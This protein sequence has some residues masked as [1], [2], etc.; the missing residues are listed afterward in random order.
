MWILPKNVYTSFRSALDTEELNWDSETFSREC[1]RSLTARSKTIVWQTW[2]R[3]LK[4]DKWMRLLYA[5][6]LPSSLSNVFEEY[7]T[8]LFWEAFHVS[9]SPEHQENGGQQK[10]PA[11]SSPSSSKASESANHQLS[12]S[13]LLK[14]LSPPEQEME[15]PFSSMSCEAWNKWV[16][17]QRQEYSARQKLARLT[18]ENESSSSQSGET[19]ATPNTF[20]HMK[21]RPEE[22]LRKQ[23]RTARKGRTKPA[24]LREQVNPRAVQIYK[25]ESRTTWPTPTA[26]DWK[27][28]SAKACANVPS[29]C[30]LGR[31]VHKYP[32]QTNVNT[33]GNPDELYLNPDWVEQLMGLE[34]GLTQ[35]PSEWID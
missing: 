17:E 20:D 9:H 33:N 35:L 11:T 6:A 22:A 16:T 21:Q 10:I 24:N 15:N 26:R 29:N 7:L 1:E 31:E 14:E 34:S 12:F 2:Q 30:L 18:K 19:W 4:R 3:K 25:E 5:R 28:G 8:L 23:A 27:D 13:N 32:D